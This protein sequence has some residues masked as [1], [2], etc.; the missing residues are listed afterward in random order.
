[1]MVHTRLEQATTL[2][3]RTANWFANAQIFLCSN[4]DEQAT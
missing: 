2:S 4:V 1:M 3:S